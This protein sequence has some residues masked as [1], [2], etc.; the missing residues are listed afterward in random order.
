M[1]TVIVGGGKAC[2]SILELQE[3]GHLQ[4][5]E[6]EVVCVVDPRSVAPGVEYARR[7][8]IPVQTDYQE[9]ITRPDVELILEMTGDRAI[10]ADLYHRIHPGVRVIDHASARVFG[11]LIRLESSL[12]DELQNR[13]DL[14]KEL[15][16]DRRRGQR[17]LDGMPDIVVVLDPDRK[18]LQ[19]NARLEEVCGIP[20][21]EAVGRD[22]ASVFCS[23]AQNSSSG[24]P[25]CP[26][27]T[28][29]ATGK[30][31][32]SII[33]GP[34]EIRS[35]YEVTACP[36]FNR[37][38]ELVEI[39]ETHHPVTER[40]L[41]RR[42]IETSEQ[43]FR[44]FID[45]AND[46]ISMKDRQGRY[47]V[48]NPAS[49]KIFGLEPLQLIGRTAEEIYDPE[50]AATI[51]AHDREVMEKKEHSTFSEHFRIQDRDYYFLTTRFPLFD[52]RGRVDGVCTIARDVT[53]ERQLQSQLLQSAKLAAVGKLAA[54]VAHEINNPLTGILAFAEDLLE[55]AAEDDERRDD[56][57]V[58]IRESLRCRG[59]VRDLLDF[60]RQEEP[61]FRTVDLN[62]VVHRTI[63]MVERLPRFRDV[64]LNQELAAETLAVL[65][66]P[67][68]L[69]QVFLN[70]IINA[71][72]A[73]KGRGEI[74][75]TSGK[76]EDA[77][78]CFVSV[79]DTGPGISAEAAEKI[80]EPF[81]STKSTSGLG[82]AVSLGIIQRHGGTIK[83]GESSGGGADFRVVF[84]TSGESDHQKRD[85]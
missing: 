34:G 37:R 35:F 4:E 28:A 80:F 66:D 51:T 32:S 65:A 3:T 1:K 25:G 23:A 75:L 55:E 76:L 64:Q 31:A 13:G 52:Y 78:S 20:A 46:I 17:M 79:Q 41:L 61:D 29:V 24:E 9:I 44:Q 2:L 67:R 5:L 26:F 47:L 12:R 68:Q 70:L 50:V 16:A 62:R 72:D 30:P 77:E 84:P 8:G 53:Q 42:E 36:Q 69:Q 85:N 21:A 22:C 63:A 15:A 83:V 54:G 60:A 14:E 33:R 49:A 10:L 82:L 71:N 6:M 38:G 19:A 58:I 59:I 73:M 57:K 56:Y 27:P 39:V 74:I 7:H 45:S 18:I 40:V 43:R 81:F 48:V 11:D